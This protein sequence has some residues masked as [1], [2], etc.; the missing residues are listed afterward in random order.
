MEAAGVG[1]LALEEGA[2]IANMAIEVV[3]KNPKLI[4][5][6]GSFIGATKRVVDVEKLATKIRKVGDDI[7]DLSEVAGGHTLEKHAGK[8]IN[9]LTKRAAKDPLVKSASSFTDTR[10]AISAAQE[11][12][13]NN[14]REIALW[15][16]DNTSKDKLI[17]DFSH[18]YSI[19][20]GVL[21]GNRTPIYDLTKSRMVLIKDAAQDIGFKILTTF[22]IVE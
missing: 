5:T 11:S 4:Q 6:E 13:R 1:K 21:K 15:L 19:G 17:I 12:L 8:G 10:T 20:Y 22:P 2:D 14:A 3:E 9:K 16:R 18:K 7:L